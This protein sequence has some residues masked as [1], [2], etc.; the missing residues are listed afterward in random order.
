MKQLVAAGFVSS[1]LTVG[2]LTVLGAGPLTPPTGPVAPTGISLDQLNASL[3]GLNPGQSIP[4]PVLAGGGVATLTFSDRTETI[5]LLGYRAYRGEGWATSNIIT[6]AFVAGARGAHV[7]P[8]GG[9][10]T[11]FTVSVTGSDGTTVGPVGLMRLYGH[12]LVNAPTIGGN[13]AI[14]IVHFSTATNP[15]TIPLSDQSG[16]GRL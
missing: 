8:P 7:D 10:T 16:A 12:E 5:P 14:H 2:L 3:A 4:G 15:P 13:K 11:L 6:I 1:L 9:L